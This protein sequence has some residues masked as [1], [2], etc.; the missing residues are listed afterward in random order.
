MRKNQI[1]FNFDSNIKVCYVGRNNEH[2]RI[3]ALLFSTSVSI[4]LFYF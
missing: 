3:E 2:F 4:I 1:L